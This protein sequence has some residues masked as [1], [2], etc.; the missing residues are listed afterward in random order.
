MNLCLDCSML[1][2][3]PE[4]VL[5]DPATLAVIAKA[6][7]SIPSDEEV[8]E[9]VRVGNMT[10]TRALELISDSCGQPQ[11]IAL[12]ER[13]DQGISHSVVGEEAQ[14]MADRGSLDMLMM[15]SSEHNGPPSLGTAATT[16]HTKV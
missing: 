14:T 4:E 13:M 8:N 2:I 12:R 3:S 7:V 1:S 6:T 10:T 16:N 11:V 9:D 15:P 5:N